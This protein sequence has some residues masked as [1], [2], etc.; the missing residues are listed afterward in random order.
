MTR[1]KQTA[2]KVRRAI[3]PSPEARLELSASEWATLN[4][5]FVR[6]KAHVAHVGAHDLT[7]H[8]ALHN[9]F[10]DLRTPG[11]LGSAERILPFR[12][13]PPWTSP[14][15]IK[16]PLSRILAPSDW[17]SR[18]LGVNRGHPDHVRIS[19]HAGRFIDGTHYVFVRRADLDRL[20]PDTVASHG[21]KRR[22]TKKSPR[23]EPPIYGMI[24]QKAAELHPQGYE[25]VKTNVL[26]DVVS[27]AFGKNAPSR[28]QIERALD[29]RGKR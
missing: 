12:S 8:D 4:E 16:E 10:H 20:Y 1:P 23:R 2:K 13:D 18:E 24:R 29:R 19:T 26:V 9:L 17:A 22:T 7:I 28:Y 6:I 21:S 5:A 3:V 27:N 15:H 11:R 25:R 14:S